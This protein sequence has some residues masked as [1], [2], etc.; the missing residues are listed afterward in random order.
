MQY[1]CELIIDL[2]WN[3]MVT[4]YDNMENQKKWMP[5]IYD[6]ERISGDGGKRTENRYYFEK[7]EVSETINYKNLPEEMMSTYTSGSVVNP[8]KQKFIDFNGKTKWI[9]EVEFKGG[10]FFNLMTAIMSGM[11]KKE[12][13]KNMQAFKNWVENQ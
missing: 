2:P 5:G 8:V 6:I 7:I 10:F 1:S 12:T 4:L 11:F 13:Q 9:M 3:L